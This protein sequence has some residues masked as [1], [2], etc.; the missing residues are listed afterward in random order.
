M[1]LSNL[2]QDMQLMIVGFF[3]TRKLGHAPNIHVTQVLRIFIEMTC[4]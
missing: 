4:Q 2:K 3:F 1:P